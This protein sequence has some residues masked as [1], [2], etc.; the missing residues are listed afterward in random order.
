MPERA[1]VP[2]LGGSIV[3]IACTSPVFTR[4]RAGE[5]SAPE[6][7]SPETVSPEAASAETAPA[8]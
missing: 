8:D 5:A 7:V 3:L 2:L 4:Y 1:V 6:T